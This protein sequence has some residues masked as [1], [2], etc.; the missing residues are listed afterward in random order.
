MTTTQTPTT[1]PMQDDPAFAGRRTM[2]QCPECGRT[3]LTRLWRGGTGQTVGQWLPVWP[4]IE[5]VLGTVH[6]EERCRG[7]IA[8]S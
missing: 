2:Q 1:R 4:P 7:E 8:T 6:D 3:I 5:P